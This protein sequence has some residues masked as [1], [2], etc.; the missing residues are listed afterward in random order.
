[1]NNINFTFPVSRGELQYY[2]FDQSLQFKDIPN[3]KI[4]N[5][6]HLLYNKIAQAER[7]LQ[8]LDFVHVVG[9]FSNTEDGIT[10][11]H[12][13]LP[14]EALGA[15]SK[16]GEN[17][18]LFNDSY[19]TGD[20]I[21]KMPDQSYQHISGFQPLGF[22]PFYTE[23]TSEPG[24]LQLWYYNG[25]T[26]DAAI[27][28]DYTGS[29]TKYTKK[30]AN[31]DSTSLSSFE[32]G[33]FYENSS[34]PITTLAKKYIFKYN[35]PT[36]AKNYG[37]LQ[38]TSPSYEASISVESGSGIVKL[39]SFTPHINNTRDNTNQY[40]VEEIQ[41]GL[42]INCEEKSTSDGNI[43]RTLKVSL[44][45]RLQTYANAEQNKNIEWWVEVK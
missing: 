43:T 23:P 8:F 19:H 3:E 16:T 34:T 13:L 41:N 27:T 24:E 45:S 9:T 20:Y 39:Y 31:G 33:H 1:M 32:N 44:V 11:S 40:D 42:N 14:G 36:T 6:F 38:L 18:I 5:N 12:K 2:P 35:T 22:L 30:E 7:D 28:V 21:L 26:N 4:M 10:K 29:Q 25:A 15:V 37:S 17:I